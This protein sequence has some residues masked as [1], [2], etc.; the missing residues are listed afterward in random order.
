VSY[1]RRPGAGDTGE[2]D[3]GEGD[4][5]DA[6]VVG[7]G[8]GTLVVVVTPVGALVVAVLTEASPSETTLDASTSNNVATAARISVDLSLISA[9]VRPVTVML[10]VTFFEAK[11]F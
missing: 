4:T 3:T 2:G 8:A 5:G 6:V 7:E 1:I 11:V 9:A 10:A